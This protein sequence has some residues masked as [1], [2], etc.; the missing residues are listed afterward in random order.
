MVFIRRWT[1]SNGFKE[2][3]GQ[4]NLKD[5]YRWSF[6]R[7]GHLTVFNILHGYESSRFIH[8]AEIEG[9]NY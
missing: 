8:V 5:H 4:G 6:Y 3:I 1:L 2:R 9:K 7:G